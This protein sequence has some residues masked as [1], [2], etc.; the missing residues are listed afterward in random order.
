MNLRRCAAR[1]R[2]NI[3]R[4]DIVDA[5]AI[6]PE[7]PVWQNGKLLYVEYGGRGVFDPWKAPF[8]GA[9]YRWSP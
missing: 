3:G 9:V 8:P 4:D 7:G 5:D 6:Y 1:L 2:R